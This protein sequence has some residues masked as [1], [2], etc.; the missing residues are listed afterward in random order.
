MPVLR[1]GDEIKSEDGGIFGVLGKVSEDR[2]SNNVLP[3]SLQALA[4]LSTALLQEAFFWAILS[5]HTGS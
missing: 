3:L 5:E 2:I 4:E 1:H